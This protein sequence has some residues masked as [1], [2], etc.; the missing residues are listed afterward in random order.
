[1]TR[2]RWIADEVSGDEAVLTG[3]NAE[4]LSRVLRARIGQQFEIATGEGV[5]LG[6]IVEIQ[7]ERVVFSL[8]PAQVSELDKD[9]LTVHLYLAIFKFDRFEWAVEKCT[10]LGVTAIVPVIAARTD[11]HLTN[12]AKKRV[13]RWRRIAYEASQQS[14]RDRPPEISNPEKL[15]KVI[16]AA[17][18]R[19]IVLSEAERGQTLLSLVN[20]SHE[21]SLAV[22]PE[23]GWTTSELD[24]FRSK[25]WSPASLG[26][27]VLRAET[28]A[29]AALAI[30]QGA[31]Q[32]SET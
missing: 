30:T 10:E 15:G 27:T 18:I 19:R 1:M 7:P 14:R 12:A 20:N 32:P 24:L 6:E 2:R 16:E 4:H 3:R 28:A 17:P 5:R 29:T 26:R 9:T 8:N 22:G 25:G 11:A 21:F 31:F 23:G 13:E